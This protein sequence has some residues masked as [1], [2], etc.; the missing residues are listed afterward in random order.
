M[1][2]ILFVFD[3]AK[4]VNS[5]TSPKPYVD[6][7]GISMLGDLIKSDMELLSDRIYKLQ[8][9]GYITKI[10][11]F[12]VVACNPDK[13]KISDV[14]KDLLDCQVDPKSVTLMMK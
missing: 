11:K 13:N 8:G 3:F 4:H 9:K 6:A 7:A 12:S 1:I 10:D 5:V 2:E 14:E